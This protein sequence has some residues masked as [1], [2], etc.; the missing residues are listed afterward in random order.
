MACNVR[1]QETAARELDHII[2]YLLSFGSET[3]KA[4]VAE[5][6]IMLETLR[7]GVVQHRLS[8]FPALAKLGYRSILLKQYVVLYYKDGNDAVVAH[9]FHQSQ[10]YARLV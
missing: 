4:F 2:R 3:A 7:D 9:V 1:I 6:E 5:W 10:D 8:R